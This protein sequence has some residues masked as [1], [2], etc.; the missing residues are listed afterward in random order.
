MFALT[1]LIVC[2]K[3]SDMVAS[4]TLASNAAAAVGLW[5][6]PCLVFSMLFTHQRLMF[7]GGK[8]W[9]TLQWSLV[10]G[11]LTCI[12]LWAIDGH[13]VELWDAGLLALW[14]VA[15][16]GVAAFAT[17]LAESSYKCLQ[18]TI[19][20][21]KVI[22]P[23]TQTF[24]SIPVMLG[25]AILLTMTTGLYVMPGHHLIALGALV[26]GASFLV[27][28]RLN[29]NRGSTARA[30]ATFMWAPIILANVLLIPA[31]A[32]TN[33]WLAFTGPNMVT[34]VDYAGAFSALAISIAAPLVGGTLASKH[35]Q[36]KA[37]L[38]IERGTNHSL[39]VGTESDTTIAALTTNSA[40][41]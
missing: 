5:L 4:T 30:I 10:L 29:A 26:V 36:A 25:G 16:I 27:V 18:S 8:A 33:V 34:W 12:S 38:G 31:L 11:Y 1:Q 41:T 13:S 24:A 3:I 32:V 15:C 9:H 20:A 40:E 6:V 21:R 22:V 14:N 19:G 2:S 7:D 39:L 37:A 28:Q 35:L 23:M 17:K